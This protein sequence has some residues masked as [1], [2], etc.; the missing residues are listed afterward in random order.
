M[1]ACAYAGPSW[2]LQKLNTS[3]YIQQRFLVR[4]TVW[5]AMFSCVTL[6]LRQTSFSKFPL[7]RGWPY[8]FV[9]IQRLLSRSYSTIQDKTL[10]FVNQQGLA[11]THHPRHML[12]CHLCK[13]AVPTHKPH[14]FILD[15]S[16]FI[17]LKVDSPISDKIYFIILNHLFIL[18]QLFIFIILLYSNFCSSIRD[19]SCHLLQPIVCK[20]IGGGDV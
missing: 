16:L 3:K 1:N 9:C 2:A 12:H 13:H 7:K 6:G 14:Y 17:Y 5:E 8:V 15:K 20:T 10:K 18:I 4:G 11:T 19:E